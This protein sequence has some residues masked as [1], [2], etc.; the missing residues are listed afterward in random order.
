MS[1]I[2]DIRIVNPLF[3]IID[4]MNLSKLLILKD[5]Y[6]CSKNNQSVGSSHKTGIYSIHY[7]VTNKVIHSNSG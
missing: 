6:S 5:I 1:V 2:C 7:R 4:V 3:S